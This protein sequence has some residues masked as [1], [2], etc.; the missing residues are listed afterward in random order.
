MLGVFPKN[1]YF[2][3]YFNPQYSCFDKK[4]KCKVVPNPSLTYRPF[5]VI[6]T[7]T[8]NRELK[9]LKIYD[10]HMDVAIIH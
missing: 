3:M 2:L 10:F 9:I 5:H 6:H 1:E 7:S 4:F 8:L